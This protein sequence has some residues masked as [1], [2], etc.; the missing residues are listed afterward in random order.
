MKR[1]MWKPPFR[2]KRYANDKYKFLVRGKV[3][4][5]WKRRYFA[6]ESEA[7]AFAEQQNTAAERTIPEP[8]EENGASR[9]AATLASPER[10]PVPAHARARDLSRLTAPVFLGPRIQRYLGDA[11]CMHLPFAYD[12]M[13]E[14]APKT[15]VELGVKEGESYFAFC[16]SAAENKISVRCYG[17]D[18]WQGDI[19]TGKLNPQIAKYV[20]SYNWQYS[21]FSELKRMLFS[22]AL[23][24]FPDGTIDLLHID[25]AHTYRDVKT[26]FESWLP[27]VSSNGL[28]LFHDVM[29]RDH[30]FGVWKVWEEIAREDNS[31]LFEFG[32][33]LGIWKKQ[34]VTAND[35]PFVQSLFRADQ[36]ERRRLNE[37]YANA[38]AALALWENLARQFPPAEQDS[39]FPF[40]AEER[41]TEL[42]RFQRE[43]DERERQMAQAQRD[44]AEKEQRAVQLQSELNEKAARLAQIQGEATDRSAQLAQLRRDLD[45]KSREASNLER[46]AANTLQELTAM[47][48]DNAGLR[49][50]CEKHARSAMLIKSQLAATE[51][52]LE[53]ASFDVLEA[54]W[55]SLTLRRDLA[56]QLEDPAPS[57]R[58]V[59]LESRIAAVG[60][61]R[62]HLRAMVS[63]LQKDLDSERSPVLEAEPQTP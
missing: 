4:G 60:S 50:E 30:G 25:G 27:K 63:A 5:K 58:L 56:L 33:G 55:E 15:F 7:V 37:S 39:P 44:L 40:E 29:V 19:Q 6:T 2:V 8:F 43:A 36:A 38:A 26:D 46:D 42:P 20:A 35:V 51:E 11:W 28:V 13:R 17:I 16:Q 12:L 18:S 14:F 52:R 31:F 10:Q 54:Q 21:S 48:E 45:Q 59:E 47:R 22:E 32:F 24:D 49:H 34:P 61:E 41:L 53:Q 1:D 62:D 3:D 9:Q 57:G 23:A